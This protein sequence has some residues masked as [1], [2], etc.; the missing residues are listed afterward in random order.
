MSTIYFTTASLDG[1]L[2][3]QDGSLDVWLVGDGELVGG[4]FD[5][6]G[7]LDEVQ[8]AIQPLILGGGAPLL[9][10]QIPPSRPELQSVQ[11]LG[12]SA[13]LTYRVTPRPST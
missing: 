8:V 9:P 7:L 5:D 13:I 12:Q 3:D 4:G 6:A 2:A 11:L 10:R 1:F